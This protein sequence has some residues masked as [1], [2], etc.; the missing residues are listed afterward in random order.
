MWK[1]A[2]DSHFPSNVPPTRMA[3]YSSVCFVLPA[4]AVPDIAP[5]MLAQSGVSFMSDYWT[6]GETSVWHAIDRV[7][8]KGVFIVVG[9]MCVQRVG[10]AITALA[11]VPGLICY[12]QSRRCVAD[13][14]VPGYDAWHAAWHVAL[15]LTSLGLLSVES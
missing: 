8:A 4:L 5:M 3:G 7:Y 2:C 12:A 9:L 11:T 6:C 1:W 14:N 10:V 13:G 15:G